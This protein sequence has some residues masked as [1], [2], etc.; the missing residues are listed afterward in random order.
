LQDAFK[1][2]FADEGF[3]RRGALPGAARQR[4]AGT[5]QADAVRSACCRIV[6]SRSRWSPTGVCPAPRARS[7]QRST[8]RPEAADRRPDRADPQE[9]DIIRV[10]GV[11]GTLEL[12]VDAEEFAAR[13]PAKGLLG[14]NIGTGR[15]LFGFMRMA[16]SSAEQG[17]SA[18]T[19]A[20]ETLN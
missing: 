20:L 10:D 5:A 7:R 1:A 8:S 9:G 15:E 14:N 4:H 16:F 6:V 12:K 13:T 2:W 19:S 17:A 11:K 3:R 18:F